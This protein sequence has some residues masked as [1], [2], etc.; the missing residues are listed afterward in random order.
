LAEAGI[1]PIDFA[2]KMKKKPTNH[3]RLMG[4]D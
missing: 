2:E 4:I 1:T 3:G